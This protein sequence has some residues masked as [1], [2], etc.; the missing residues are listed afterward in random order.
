M[1]PMPKGDR[2]LNDVAHLLA[3]RFSIN[4]ATIQLERH[5]SDVICNQ[6]VDCA[7]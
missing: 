2:F 7:N 4:H 1:N 5:D 6:S 3:D